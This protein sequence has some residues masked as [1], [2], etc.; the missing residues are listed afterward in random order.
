MSDLLTQLNWKEAP[1]SPPTTDNGEGW[2]NNGWNN[3]IF[4]QLEN[5]L[6]MIEEKGWK[7]TIHIGRDVVGRLRNT[8][9]DYIRSLMAALMADEDARGFTKYIIKGS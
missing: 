9:E 4:N 6:W 2:N 7:D 8:P 3:K 1:P 5:L